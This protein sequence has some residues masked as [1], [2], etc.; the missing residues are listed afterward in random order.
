MSVPNFFVRTS[1]IR[2][3]TVGVS[4]QRSRLRSLKSSCS[5]L[6]TYSSKIAV[7]RR[8]SSGTTGRAFIAASSNSSENSPG[9]TRRKAASNSWVSVS[10]PLKMRIWVCSAASCGANF[11][12]PLPSS[13][14]AVGP[15][16]VGA[17]KAVPDDICMA[18]SGPRTVR[19]RMSYCLSGSSDSL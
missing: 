5:V 7:P 3:P 8:N 10:L 11:I 18:R 12:W 17:T 6:P 4:D 13:T 19:L 15:P 14:T 2:S 1:A 9:L 16:G